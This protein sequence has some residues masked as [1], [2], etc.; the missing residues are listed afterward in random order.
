MNFGILPL[1]F[2]SEADSSSLAEGC[3]IEITGIKAALEAGSDLS[4]LDMRSGKRI[5][6]TYSLSKRQRAIL[7]AGGMLNYTKTRA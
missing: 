7:L 6:L 2:V 4:L 3:E 1:V 5:A